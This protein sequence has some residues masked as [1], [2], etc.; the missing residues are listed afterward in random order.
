MSSVNLFQSLDDHLCHRTLQITDVFIGSLY[1]SISRVRLILL[2][3][4]ATEF[5]VLLLNDVAQIVEIFSH[6]TVAELPGKICLDLLVGR[7]RN[8]RSDRL[9]KIGKRRNYVLRRLYRRVEFASI[10][11]GLQYLLHQLEMSANPR[12]DTNIRRSSTLP[13][14][15]VSVHYRPKIAICY[16]ACSRQCFIV[17]LTRKKTWCFRFLWKDTAEQVRA[18]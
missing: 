6:P 2:E 10:S 16:F 4:L 18:N 15:R 3:L 8:K 14:H 12:I 11:E 17:R 13:T 1:A 9:D 5:L 7:R